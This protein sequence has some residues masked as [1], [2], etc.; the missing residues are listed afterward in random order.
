[1]CRFSDCIMDLS[2]LGNNDSEVN[3]VFRYGVMSFW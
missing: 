2:S 1:M 3:R